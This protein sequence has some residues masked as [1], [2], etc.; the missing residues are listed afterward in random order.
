MGWAA[1]DAAGDHH[2]TRQCLQHIRQR[3]SG[4]DLLLLL[5][6]PSSGL[7]SSRGC[8]LDCRPWLSQATLLWQWTASDLPTSVCSRTPC[9]RLASLSVLSCPGCP[10]GLA[11]TRT[12]LV[13]VTCEFTEHRLYTAFVLLLTLC[14]CAGRW[15]AGRQ[16]TGIVPALCRAGLA[17]TACLVAGLPNK[18]SLTRCPAG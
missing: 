9:P 10:F 15:P 3:R 2:Q 14:K 12:T 4:K 6:E 13:C 7:K 8:R 11:H 16:H 1:A 18:A 17:R 5:C